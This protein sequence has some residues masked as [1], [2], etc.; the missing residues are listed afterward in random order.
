M[1]PIIRI[2]LSPTTTTPSAELCS[3]MPAKF[4]TVRK[5]GLTTVPTTISSTR[6]GSSATSRS[7]LTFTPRSRDPTAAPPPRGSAARRFDPLVASVA[8]PAC[9]VLGSRSFRCL[10]GGVALRCRE[11]G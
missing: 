4:E 11:S 5:A 2:R 3:P 6:T 8:R 1:P 10:L 9:R 7:T